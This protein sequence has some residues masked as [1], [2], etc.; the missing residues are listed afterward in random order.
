MKMLHECRATHALWVIWDAEIDGD[1]H[2]EV[3]PEES[4]CHVKQG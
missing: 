3:W 4:Q 2:F 1:I